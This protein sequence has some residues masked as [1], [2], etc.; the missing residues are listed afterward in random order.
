MSRILSILVFLAAVG[1]QHSTGP[2]DLD[3]NLNAAGGDQVLSTDRQSYSAGTTVSLRLKNSYRHALGY[4]LCQAVL[5]RESGAS[6]RAAEFENDRVCTMELRLL[7][8]GDS[9]VTSRRLDGRLAEGNYRFRT[10]V[11]NMSTGSREPVTSNT[12]RLTR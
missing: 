12:F 10:T 4:N 6:W 9:V 11:E 2:A 7:Q 1:C 3:P 8:P 5:E